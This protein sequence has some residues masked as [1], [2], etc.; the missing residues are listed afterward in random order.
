MAL[1]HPHF[2][3]ERPVLASIL[4]DVI[5]I[6]INP[7]GFLPDLIL[8]VSKRTLLRGHDLLQVYEDKRLIAAEL[9]HALNIPFLGVRAPLVIGVGDLEVLLHGPEGG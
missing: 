5:D 7:G 1:F 6:R 8:I 3:K 9:V 2:G 4:V